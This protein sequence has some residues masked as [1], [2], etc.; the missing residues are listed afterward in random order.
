[1][2]KRYPWGRPMERKKPP[3]KWRQMKKKCPRLWQ[4]HQQ[5]GL[6]K[7]TRALSPLSPP[8]SLAQRDRRRRRWE[9]GK[10]NPRRHPKDDSTGEW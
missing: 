10:K 4:R 9:L 8:D 2:E 5:W 6:R 3:V 7:T 1:M